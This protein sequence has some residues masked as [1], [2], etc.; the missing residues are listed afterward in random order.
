M[1]IIVMISIVG[2]TIRFSLKIQSAE[3]YQYPEDNRVAM[4]KR[5]FIYW[6]GLYRPYP[7]YPSWVKSGKFISDVSSIRFT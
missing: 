2:L 4:M 3:Y 1:I 7:L 5:C 6:M